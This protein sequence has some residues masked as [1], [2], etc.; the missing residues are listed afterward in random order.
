LIARPPEIADPG[1]AHERPS[2]RR[3]AAQTQFAGQIDLP[4]AGCRNN[5][6]ANPSVASAA[7][8]RLA[9][10]TAPDS[11]SSRFANILPQI[12]SPANR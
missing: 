5:A 4:R 9:N 3:L 8:I 1:K 12:A 2:G 6:N 7:P 10:F 11:V